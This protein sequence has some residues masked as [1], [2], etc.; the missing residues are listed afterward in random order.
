MKPLISLLLSIILGVL[1][2]TVVAQTPSQQDDDVIR[3]RTAE[4]KL[5]VVVKDKKG[6]PVK[7]LKLSDFEVFEDGVKQKVESFR[8][9]S[10]EGTTRTEQPDSKPTGAAPGKPSTTHQH[11]NDHSSGTANQVHP[12]SNSPGF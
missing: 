12:F 8:F 7:D 3:T 2:L 11:G 10:T 5:D 6:R 9:V 1:P 4:V